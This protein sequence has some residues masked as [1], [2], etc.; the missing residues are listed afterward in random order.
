MGST[1]RR[2]ALSNYTLGDKALEAEVFGFFLAQI[3]EMTTSSQVG[4]NRAGLEDPISGIQMAS[5]PSWGVGG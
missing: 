5:K 2:P 1:I 4:G 3:P